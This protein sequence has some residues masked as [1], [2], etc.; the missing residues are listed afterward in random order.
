MSSGGRRAPRGIVGES[1]VRRSAHTQERVEGQT[2]R[3]VAGLRIQ[4]CEHTRACS[5]GAHTQTIRV[6]KQ[7]TPTQIHTLLQTN[8]TDTQMFGA[9]KR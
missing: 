1:E 6:C 5:A 8:Q 9:L 7:Q 2:C 4:M 3:Q